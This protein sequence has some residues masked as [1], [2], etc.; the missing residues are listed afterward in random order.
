MGQRRRIG[1]PSSG[2]PW[3]SSLY[4]SVLGTT[5]VELLRYHNDTRKLIRLTVD[6]LME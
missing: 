4:V 3:I 6:E 2:S 5:A 1:Y